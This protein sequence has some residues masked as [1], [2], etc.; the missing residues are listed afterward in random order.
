MAVRIE[1]LDYQHIQSN[2]VTW[3][4]N[5]VLLDRDWETY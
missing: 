1:F 2:L 4:N 3:N 5:A